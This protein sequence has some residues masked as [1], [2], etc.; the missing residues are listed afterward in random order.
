MALSRAKKHRQKQL[1]EFSVRVNAFKDFKPYFQDVQLDLLFGYAPSFEVESLFILGL[2]T[3]LR[4]QIP[5]ERYPVPTVVRKK[6]DGYRRLVQWPGPRIM[7]CSKCDRF[8]TDQDKFDR[9]EC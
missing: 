1:E 4:S 3:V 5:Y 6:L 9:H 2:R 7:K 8:Y